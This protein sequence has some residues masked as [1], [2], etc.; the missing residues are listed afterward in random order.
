VFA[1]LA[2]DSLSGPLDGADTGLY[3]VDLTV[4]TRSN[5]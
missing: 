4:G 3:T 2:A 1:R 5:Q